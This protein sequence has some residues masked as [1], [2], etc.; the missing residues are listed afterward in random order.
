MEMTEQIAEFLEQN[1]FG[2]FDKDGI[3]GNI[4][5]NSLPDKPN[6][7]MAVYSTGGPTSDPF[8]TYGRASIQLIIRSIPNDPRVTEVK[9]RQ[10]IE[11]LHGF[12]SNF[13]AFGG[14]RIYDISAQQSEPNNIGPD[15]K[16]RFEF[17]QNFIIE[18][19]K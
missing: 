12:N 16:N 3:S 8:G 17:S 19:V 9:T 15:Q 13:L 1:G 7:A 5:I 2:T 6:E 18:Y 10:I 14:H 4:F 11:S